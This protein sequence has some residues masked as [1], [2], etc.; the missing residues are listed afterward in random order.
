MFFIASKFPVFFIM[1]TL[2]P[3][4]F[5]MDGE[6]DVAV[7]ASSLLCSFVSDQSHDRN[8]KR[9]TLCKQIK[10]FSESQFGR[11]DATWESFKNTD[12][13][14]TD[15]AVVIRYLCC[16]VVILYKWIN[17]LGSLLN[18]TIYIYSCNFPSMDTQFK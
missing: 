3:L 2:L 15:T 12:R 9:G 5:F 13:F 1:F 4:P 6:G 14:F 18:F 8:R 16:F 17:S 7:S 10:L 11:K